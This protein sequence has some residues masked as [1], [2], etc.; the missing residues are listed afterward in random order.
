MAGLGWSPLAAVPAAVAGTAVMGVAF[1]WLSVKRSG[2]FF[3]MVTLALAQFAYFALSQSDFTGGDNGLQNVPR[4]TLLGLD[5]RNDHTLYYVV[6]TIVGGCL[7]LLRRIVDSPFGQSMQLV[8]GSEHRALSLGYDVQKIKWKVFVI[9]STLTAI[10]GALKV[11]AVQFASL[12]DVNFEMSGD[13][14]MMAVIGGIGSIPGAAIGAVFLMVLQEYFASFGGWIQAVQGLLFAVVV[15]FFP[16][17]L[18]GGISY[19]GS[20]LRRRFSSTAVISSGESRRQA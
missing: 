6:L 5:L 3:S 18:Y 9:S 8:K 10:A 7:A 2:M 15:L 12:A 13:I 4:G 16:S 11:D 1:G 19:I 14:L 17:G 20:A